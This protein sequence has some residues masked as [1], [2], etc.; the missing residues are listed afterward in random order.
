MSIHAVLVPVPAADAPPGEAL[1]QVAAIEAAHVEH[2]LGHADL[3]EPPEV[4]A[5]GYRAQESV[6]KHYLLARA[7]EG[8]AVGYASVRLPV[9]DNLSVAHVFPSWLPGSAPE[10]EVYDALW[11]ESLPLIEAGGRTVVH[12][13]TTHPTGDIGR[14]WV[15]PSS[16]VGRLGRDD[17]AAWLEA[18][19]FVLE[20]V[21][22]A[23]TLTVTHELIAAAHEMD[24]AAEDGIR[25]QVVA[26]PD[27]G[28]A[29]GQH[30]E[31]AGA[32]ERRRA[33]RRHGAGGPALGRERGGAPG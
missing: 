23:S 30:G 8:Q 3:A 10:T 11:A 13:W 6:R 12:T 27:T 2:V 19:G 20:Q 5:A 16:G 15:E 14:G 25:R 1:E 9:K 18:Q 28:G 21:E 29:A 32:D 4:Y 33:Q 7:T 26:R 31:A 22:L 24:A 17:R